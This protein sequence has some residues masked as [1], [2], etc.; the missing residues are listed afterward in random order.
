MM[1]DT[2]DNQ[3]NDNTTGNTTG[4]DTTGDNAQT[5]QNA[6]Q[7][8]NNSSGGDANTGGDN[9]TTGSVSQA[10]YEALMKRMQA[11]DRAKTAAEKKLA[12][13]AKKDL[14]EAER[15]KQEAAE[16]KD[17]ADKAEAKLR[18]EKIFNAFLAKTDVAWH[19][20]ND[21]FTMFKNSYMDGVDIADDKVTGIEPAIKKL[22][23]EKAYLVK[24]AAG[25]S[26]ST[27]AAH[28]G[29]RKGNQNDTGKEA[30]MA[31]FPAAYGPR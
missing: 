1:S 20:V 19:D 16:A 11:A 12:D 15:F 10:D 25:S 13:A 27:G 18:D 7:G 14:D 21:A 5:S 28:N 4:S 2:G 9:N 8:D 30:R 26:D 23:K 3:N 17:R 29:Q 31:R 24:S 6:N 22:A